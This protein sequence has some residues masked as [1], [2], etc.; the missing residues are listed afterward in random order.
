MKIELH[1]RRDRVVDQ[2]GEEN[3]HDDAEIQTR[4]RL[5]TLSRCQQVADHHNQRANHHADED[6]VGIAELVFPDDPGQASAE[7]GD[8]KHEDGPDQY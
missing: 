5:D 8:D 1:G 3:S 4:N 6:D 7:T 2:V